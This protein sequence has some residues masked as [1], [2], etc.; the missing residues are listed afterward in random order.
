MRNKILTALLV[1]MTLAA[2]KRT[3]TD[4]EVKRVHASALLID[5]HNDFP[6]E[7]AG[8]DRPFTGAVV[9]IGVPSP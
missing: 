1:T 3:V 2:Q 9:D 6:T 4:A 7:Q 8:Q 5:T